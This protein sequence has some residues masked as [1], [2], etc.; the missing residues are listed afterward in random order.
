MAYLGPLLHI[1]SQDI[2]KLSAGVLVSSKISTGEESI[3]NHAYMVVGKSQFLEICWT[4]G[5]TSL[6]SP[7]YRLS[8]LL[9]HG[10]S[11]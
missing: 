5:L 9:H 7:G 1:L 4:E 6:L 8:S 2:K 11:S 3:S 10:T